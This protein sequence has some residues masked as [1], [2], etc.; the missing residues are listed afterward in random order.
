MSAAGGRPADEDPAA[1]ADLAMGPVCPVPISEYPT[2]Q[3][4]HGGGGRLTQHLIERMFV[5]S[6]S[7]PEL[8]RQ[9][10]G[11]VLAGGSERLAF[12]TD[13]YVVRPL[14]FPG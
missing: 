6:F 7:N 8:A 14:F 4:A 5:P 10:D 3:M 11:A 9:H 13:S 2:V 12:S 1:P